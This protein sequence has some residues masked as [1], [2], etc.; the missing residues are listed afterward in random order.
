MSLVAT[1]ADQCLLSGMTLRRG[2]QYT[3][4]VIR[5]ST[6]RTDVRSQRKCERGGVPEVFIQEW[7]V[8]MVRDSDL[9][10]FV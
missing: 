8:G 7:R 5:A 9:G 3:N 2:I 1:G 6:Q 4:A 10:L